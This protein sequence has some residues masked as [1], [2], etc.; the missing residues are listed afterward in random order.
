MWMDQALL[1]INH[2]GLSMVDPR[3]TELMMQQAEIFFFGES[4]AKPEGW[5]PEG[6]SEG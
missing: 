5:T 3:A 2:Y 6:S 4:D 1:I